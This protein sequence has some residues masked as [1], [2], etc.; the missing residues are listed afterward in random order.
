MTKKGEEVNI[1]NDEPSQLLETVEVATTDGEFYIQVYADGKFAV[2][3]VNSPMIFLS[4]EDLN[5][6]GTKLV[7]LASK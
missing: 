3:S 1:Y 4:K 5:R 6:L 7:E 2:D